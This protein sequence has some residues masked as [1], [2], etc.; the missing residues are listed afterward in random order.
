[1]LL[2]LRLLL[3]LLLLQREVLKVYPTV[4]STLSQEVL[5]NLKGWPGEGASCCCCA[6]A[7]SNSAV[8]H[9]LVVARVQVGGAN[10]AHAC[11]WMRIGQYQYGHCH[12]TFTGACLCVV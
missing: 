5:A 3:L 10:E 7:S 1:V 6:A 2:L 8:S 9:Q 11:I 4:E 12:G